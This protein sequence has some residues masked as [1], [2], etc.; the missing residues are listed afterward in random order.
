M[1]SVPT[2]SVVV[3]H[4]AVCAEVTV[5]AE[6]PVMAAPFALNAT[7]PVGASGPAGVIVAVKVTGWP[8]LDGFALD[9]NVMGEAA[10]LT[11]CDSVADMLPAALA[12]PA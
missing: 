6:Q 9:T 4:V 5:A 2:A 11:S 7:V 3:V 10:L 12:E 8:P 1:E